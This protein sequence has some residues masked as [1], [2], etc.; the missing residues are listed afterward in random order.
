VRATFDYTTY[1]AP[2]GRA[3][4]LIRRYN[5]THSAPEW[6]DIEPGSVFDFN[7]FASGAQVRQTNSGYCAKSPQTSLRLRTERDPDPQAG[8]VAH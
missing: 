2:K 5:G 1:D 3:V 4:T 8:N 6:I 7:S